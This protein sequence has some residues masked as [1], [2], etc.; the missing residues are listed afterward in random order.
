MDSKTKIFGALALG[1]AG[2]GTAGYAAT[3]GMG[4]RDHEA[5]E[6]TAEAAALADAKISLV[7]AVALAERSTNALA[8]EAEFEAED[9]KAVFEV[10]LYNAAGQELE[11]VIDANTGKVLRSG[12]DDEDNEGGEDAD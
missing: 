6:D 5:M 2:L 3:T 4:A 12:P 9:G 11:A 7:D 8:A 10:G 1:L